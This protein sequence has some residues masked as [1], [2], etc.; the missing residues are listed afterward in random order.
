MSQ[1]KP[2]TQ[3]DFEI[4]KNTKGLVFL[5]F[6]APWCGPCKVMSPVV[7]QMVP[8]FPQVQF[9]KVDVD[10]EGGLANTFSVQSIPSFY[11]LN[12]PGDGTFD[13]KRDVVGKIVGAISPFEFKQGIEAMIKKAQS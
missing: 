2:I 6:W 13:L 9:G 8:E 4:L 1:A 10:E 5:D 12:M 3:T 7:D 11:L